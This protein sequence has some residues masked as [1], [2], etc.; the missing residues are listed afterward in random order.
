MWGQGLAATS[1]PAAVPTS[2]GED[3][4]P[5]SEKQKPAESA[6]DQPAQPDLGVLEEDDVPMIVQRVFST[7]ALGQEIEETANTQEQGKA[8]D[9][10]IEQE[11]HKTKATQLTRSYLDRYAALKT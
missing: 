8:R 10:A 3:A 4:S 7:P 6:V 1:A 2:T 5:A 9:S 11:L